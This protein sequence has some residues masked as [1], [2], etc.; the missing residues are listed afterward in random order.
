[1][2]A[3]ISYSRSERFWLGLLAL[4][5]LIGLNGAFFYGLLFQPEALQGA[6]RNPIALAF[7]I[8]AMLLLVVL[9][10]L[11]PRWGVSR[12]SS[13]WFVILSLLGGIAFALPVV[14]LWRRRENAE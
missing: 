10:W 14:V 4:I 8:E 1:M 13:L 6:L 7:I 2:T 5:S 12:L 11:L 3:V 9:A